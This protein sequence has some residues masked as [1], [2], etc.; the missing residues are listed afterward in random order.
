MKREH[1][2][3]VAIC[4][5]VALTTT[6]SC[7]YSG[8]IN[9]NFYNYKNMSGNRINKKVYLLYDTNFE[10]FTYTFNYH[11]FTV[12]NKISPGFKNALYKSLSDVFAEV[13]IFSSLDKTQYPDADL[14][15]VPEISITDQLNNVQLDV[16]DFKT[17]Q[18]LKTYKYSGNFG[19]HVSGAVTAYEITNW[20]YVFSLSFIFFP[21]IGSSLKDSH[22]NAIESSLTVGI[23]TITRNMV[24]DNI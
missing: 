16:K 20:V 4:L 12:N 11:G 19:T 10:N 5:I 22:R 8:I 23:D 21:L 13:R 18:T 17:K 24:T 9:D 14:L 1:R 15:I 6:T 2:M 3:A 7:T